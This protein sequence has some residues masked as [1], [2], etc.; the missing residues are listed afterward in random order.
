M[1]ASFCEYLEASGTPGEDPGRADRTGEGG[2][3]ADGRIA[4]LVAMGR[5]AVDVLDGD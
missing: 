5:C 3:H 1:A 2:P 4:G